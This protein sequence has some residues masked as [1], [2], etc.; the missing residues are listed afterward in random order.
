M[1]VTVPDPTDALSAEIKSTRPHW[2]VH[3]ACRQQTASVM[4]LFSW[5]TARTD[6]TNA[7]DASTTMHDRSCSC[8][9]TGHSYLR[10]LCAQP[11]AQG[12][13][14]LTSTCIYAQPASQVQPVQTS[15]RGITPASDAAARLQ[16]RVSRRPFQLLRTNTKSRPPIEDTE[17]HV[18]AGQA[19]RRNVAVM[20]LKLSTF[21]SLL[22]MRACNR[23]C[24]AIP[25]YLQYCAPTDKPKL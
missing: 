23:G 3:V 15:K 16:I 5:R 19:R 2:H 24:G 12:W 18:G 13:S 10:S 17:A 4:P 7:S 25:W 6:R 14:L 21:T 22:R 8:T 11:S 20:W 1:Y 9:K